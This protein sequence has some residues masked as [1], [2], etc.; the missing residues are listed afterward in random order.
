MEIGRQ[1]GEEKGTGQI[2]KCW[3]GITC[4]GR[5]DPVGQCYDCEDSNMSVR[6]WTMELKQ[7]LYNTGLAHVWTKQQ[8]CNLTEITKIMKDRYNDTERQNILAK[9]YRKTH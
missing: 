2:V 1:K 4:L 5:E 9:L 3:Y 8:Q 6:S 7:S